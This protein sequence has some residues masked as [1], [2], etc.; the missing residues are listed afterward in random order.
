MERDE[1]EERAS[2]GEGTQQQ[3]DAIEALPEGGEAPREEPSV[4]EED[5][6]AG[7]IFLGGLSW[8][9]NEGEATDGWAAALGWVL[10]AVAR[11]GRGR[12]GRRTLCTPWP[13]A[14]RAHPG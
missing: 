8:E 4:E 10:S 13:T 11:P 9:T 6:R 3:Q 2:E 7:K 12:G 5:S 1:N 14:R